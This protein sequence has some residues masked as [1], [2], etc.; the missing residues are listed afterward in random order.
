MKNGVKVIGTIYDLEKLLWEKVVDELI[1]SIPLTKIR[2]AEKYIFLAE[3]IGVTIRIL[4]DWHIRRFAHK[5]SIGVFQIQD[6][7]G[8]P[9]LSL[10]TGP[11]EHS[12]LLIKSTIDYVFASLLFVFSLPFFIIF[13]I[14][15][16]VISRGPLLFKQERIGINGRRFTLYKFRTMVADAEKKLKELKAKNEMTGPVFKRL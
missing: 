13:P 8:T 2:S 1:F 6:F 12:L 16:K 3:K 4:P 14:A 15:I 7:L 11:Q 10:A 9:T 5:P